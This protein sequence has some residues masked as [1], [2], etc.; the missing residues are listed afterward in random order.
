MTTQD[1]EALASER[2]LRVSQDPRFCKHD[3][4]PNE[5]AQ[6]NELWWR[7]AADARG[8]SFEDVFGGRW[9]GR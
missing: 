3:L 7:R 5:Q 1:Y 8:V 6:A 9:W 2:V 4:S